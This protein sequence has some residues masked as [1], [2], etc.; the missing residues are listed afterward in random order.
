MSVQSTKLR[1]YVVSIVSHT[2]FV[3]VG[4]VVATL[5]QLRPKPHKMSRSGITISIEETTY[6]EIDQWAKA[7]GYR[8]PK[9][10]RRVR[11]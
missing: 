5:E 4:A 6:N 3:S 7:H 8:Q 11:A 1:G 10:R 9:E 2:V